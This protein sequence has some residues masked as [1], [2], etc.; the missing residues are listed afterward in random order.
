ML[1]LQARVLVLGALIIP[2]V[3]SQSPAFAQGPATGVNVNVVNTA[4]NVR[5]ADN[6]AFAAVTITFR[7]QDDTFTA[8][9]GWV[10]QGSSYTVPSGKRLVIERVAGNV[11]VDSVNPFKIMLRLVESVPGTTSV[12]HFIG[13]STETMRCALGST[14]VGV[15][16]QT[17]I[18]VDAGHSIRPESV[19]DLTAASP[20]T[21]L[22]GTVNGY[23]VDLP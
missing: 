3:A 17:Q 22:T 10:L 7:D 15:G 2:G 1:F 20:R 18:Y 11:T 8:G 9:G 4:L 21:V 14:C 13:I 5:S 6:P 19:L 12:S 23:L 16:E